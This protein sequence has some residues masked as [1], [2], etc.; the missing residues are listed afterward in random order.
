MA[1]PRKPTFRIMPDPSRVTPGSEAAPEAVTRPSSVLSMGEAGKIP[2]SPMLFLR[3][4]TEDT[5][6]NAELAEVP[7]VTS[8]ES[9]SAVKAPSLEDELAAAK[10]GGVYMVGIWSVKN[11]QLRFWHTLRNFPNGDM[12]LA[13]EQVT[14]Q[15]KNYPRT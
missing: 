10:E 8:Q 7:I 15:L 2:Q 4:P 3:P 11:G 9:S 14:T 13:L 12:D 1:E 5:N 6:P